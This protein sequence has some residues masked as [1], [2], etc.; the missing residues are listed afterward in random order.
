MKQKLLYTLMMLCMSFFSSTM[1]AERERP[2]MPEASLE[3]GN[4]YYL[5]NVETNLLLNYN[6]YNPMT[7][8]DATAFTIEQLDNGAY[9]L[10]NNSY[11]YARDTYFGYYSYPYSECYFDITPENDIFLISRSQLN[12]YYTEGEYIGVDDK[13][14]VRPNMPID[15]KV[16]WKLIPA[17]EQGDR[18][19][20]EMK[21]Y[22]ALVK[23]DEYASRG[24]N[25]AYYENM[26]NQRASNTA[27][28]IAIAAK[29]LN[30]GTGMS[31]GYKAPYWN[32]SPIYWQTSD[33]NFGNSYYYTWA[34][35]GSN[36]T[37]GTEFYRFLYGN[38][39][40]SI[41]ATVTIDEPSVF[42][43][44]LSAAYNYNVNVY[45]DDVLVRSL[46]NE[47]V[48]RSISAQGKTE[49]AR[50]FEELTPG[51]HTITWVANYS[52]SSSFYAEV[53]LRNIGVMKSP[54][55]TV[56]LLEPG[57]LGTEVL[58]NTDHIKNVR[59]LKVKGKMN[60]DDWSKIK[61]MS[62]LQDLDLSEAEITEIPEK[63][64]S[65]DADTSSWF[66]HKIVLPE[67][68]TKI[69]KSAFEYSL[70]DSINIPS[71]TKRIEAYAF[72]YSHIKELIL[73]DNLTDFPNS[74]GRYDDY[75]DFKTFAYMY[76][77]ENLVCPK[78]L[79]SIPPSMFEDDFY[80][81][82][83]VLPESIERI[84]ERAFYRN[85][86]VPFEFPQSLRTI[87]A[88]AF[89]DCY[90]IKHITIPFVTSIGESAFEG[91]IGAEDAE[92]G[93]TIFD[94]A[95]RVFANCS[96][97]QTLRLDC[98]TVVS[99]EADYSSYYPVDAKHIKDVNLVVPQ[100][101][102]TSYKLDE[103]WY[104]FKSITGFCTDEIQDWTISRALTLNHDR[105]EGN[106]NITILGAPDRLP[107]LKINGDYA[108]QINNLTCGGNWYNYENCPGQILSQCNNVTVKGNAAVDV[109]SEAKYWY[110]IS[111]PFDTKIS[112]IYHGSE[113]IQKAIRYYDGANRATV[114]AAGSW[115]N[116]DAD[117]II[118]AGTGFIMQTNEYTW[119]RFF[120]VDNESKQNIVSNKEFVKTLD[121]ND[122]E[123][124]SNKGWNLVGNPWQCFYNT[125]MLNFTGP[126]TVWNTRNKT[127]S[128]YSITDDDYALRPNEAFFVQCPNE[129]YNTIGFPTQGRQLNAIIESQNAVKGEMTATNRR[130][131]INLAISNGE[132]EDQTRVVLNEQ[133]SLSY[134]TTCDAS[135]F[136]SMDASVPQLYTMDAQGIQYAINERPLAEGNI[137]L[138]FYAAQTGKLTI[139]ALRCD[140]EQVFLT[141]HLTGETIEIT[142]NGYSFEA[143]AGSDN[144]RFTMTFI[145]NDAT[146][147]ETIDVAKN[148]RTEFFSVDG[149]FL[150]T[151]MSKL[152]NGIYVVRQGKK[153]TK[154]SVR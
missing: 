104:N 127:Y 108:Q 121:V 61:M 86:R 79:T 50:F 146:A 67:G 110:F 76:W 99:Y 6:D 38:E 98:P 129:E 117:A 111:L 88:R 58:Y 154:V 136:M 19:V 35:N 131:I 44:S 80:C 145:P 90:S 77:L 59:R 107:S 151:D 125:H 23:A 5:Y 18:F 102:M 65:C 112:D 54:Q 89:W 73:P 92:V 147:V 132:V 2:T 109:N 11:L 118:P 28:D 68:L 40:S 37:S 7:G 84:G 114:G 33:G 26:Y 150:G 29:N 119:S 139:S 124:A 45:V 153:V 49:Y 116:Y 8:E 53:Y 97:L 30:N 42:V 47:Q 39:T 71:T 143:Q 144:S 17:N 135:K 113:N 48:G 15:G 122:S 103:Y 93:V 140:A 24:W 85:S 148:Q 137:N 34:L 120:A 3:I 46:V 52:A 20:A 126:I 134:E 9:T 13:G 100:H 87:G 32:E 56:S 82:S 51:V 1:W 74:Y 69:S 21:L 55:I 10:K 101:I 31:A 78:N 123:N 83:V 142:Y 66:L 25:I 138:G 72:R 105:F 81:K 70:V 94:L 149:K 4:S 27:E 12:A 60:S 43:Y 141:D 75:Y 63:Q 22:H 96:N 130:Q 14:I 133:A 152:G 128:A 62:Y 16:H 64:F 41:S 106:P 115:K 91:C 57:S 36:Y 95:S